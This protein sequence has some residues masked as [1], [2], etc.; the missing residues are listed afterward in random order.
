MLLSG[1]SRRAFFSKLLI[2]IPVLAMGQKAVMSGNRAVICD[3]ESVLCPNGH[4]TCRIIDAPLV[5]GNDNRE[6]P[7]QAQLFGFHV[8]RCSECHVLFTRE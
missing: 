6:Y 5:V 2:G 7:D 8:L 1:L 3:S 4:K